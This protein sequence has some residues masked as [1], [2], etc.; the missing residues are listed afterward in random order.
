MD[1]RAYWKGNEAILIARPGRGLILR[2]PESPHFK[3]VNFM[4]GGEVC[5]APLHEDG[6]IDVDEIGCLD[7]RGWD[8][9]GEGWVVRQLNKPELID[10]RLRPY[11]EVSDLYF[12]HDDFEIRDPT[13]SE[14][15]RFKVEPRHY[16]FMKISPD[17]TLWYRPVP[18]G[19]LVVTP[20]Q[21]VLMDE[22]GQILAARDI[23]AIPVP[24]EEETPV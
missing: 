11:G 23:D 9:E 7:P 17:D 14:C 8:F 19:S 13:L 18:Q 1:F 16:G 6:L 2:C 4:V 5:S 24:G 10:I 12:E 20:T 3:E 21:V 15:G 22:S